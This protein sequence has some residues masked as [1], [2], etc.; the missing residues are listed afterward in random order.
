MQYNQYIQLHLR[1][2]W[3]HTKFVFQHIHDIAD[4]DVEISI[5]VV[6][7]SPAYV[8]ISLG[9]RIRLMRRKCRWERNVIIMTQTFIYDTGE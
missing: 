9:I 8:Y 4:L 5:I 2:L 6:A 7:T 3:T 1:L